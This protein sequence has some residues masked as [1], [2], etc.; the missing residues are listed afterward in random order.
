MEAPSLAC[1][2]APDSAPPAA[3]APGAAAAA[4]APAPGVASLESVASSG[5]RSPGHK[6]KV[7]A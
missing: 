2:D 5:N 4:A 3:A 6:K 7:D 1:P